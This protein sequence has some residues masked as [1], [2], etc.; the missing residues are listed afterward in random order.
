M[1]FGSSA[2]Y[3]TVYNV[4]SVASRTNLLQIELNRYYKLSILSLIILLIVVVRWYLQSDT[5]RWSSWTPKLWKEAS[6][7]TAS[8]LTYYTKLKTLSN[9]YSRRIC[10]GPSAGCQLIRN[11][12]SGLVQAVE[13]NLHYYHQTDDGMLLFKY[14]NT[15]VKYFPSYSLLLI[16]YRRM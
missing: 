1:L 13:M 6:I 4:N 16:L 15:V 7:S 11:N 5:E 2:N 14:L 12:F 9:I 3:T 10:F 8:E